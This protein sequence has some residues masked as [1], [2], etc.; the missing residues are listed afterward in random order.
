M[1]TGTGGNQAA[2][3]VLISAIL[4]SSMAFIDQS[5]LDVAAPRLQADLQMTGTQLF[6]V[7]TA[8]ALFLASLLLVGGALGDLYGRKRIFMIGI[9]IF[10]ASSI[11]CGLA[12]TAELLILSRAVQ[13][14]GGAL[15]IPGSL[16]MISAN[17]SDER[18]G[19][20]IGTWS[21][22][23][24]LTTLLGPLVGGWLAERGLWRAVFLINV[25][26]GLIALYLLASRVPES[27]SETPTRRLDWAGA[28]T[29]TLSLALF[30]IGFTL[31]QNADSGPL[32]LLMIVGGIGAL[33][34]FLVIESRIEHP[35][36]PLK[37]F[38]NRTFS[39]TNAL[40]LLLYG[41]LRVA[42]F[43][44][45]L[46]LQQIQGYP[47]DVAGFAFLPFALCLIALSRL[48][49]GLASRLGPR[50]FLTLGPAL[51]GVGFLLLGLPGQTGGVSDY[52]TTFFPGTLVL[53]VGMGLTVAPLTT[54][55]MSAAPRENSG[56]A[57]GINN[58]ISRVAAVLALT[59]VGGI[60]LANFQGGLAARAETLGLSEEA[61]VELS[62]NSA[63]LGA[64]E[65]PNGLSADQQTQV[66]QAIDESFL[67]VNRLVSVISAVLA[68]LSALIAFVM[69]EPK[70]QSEPPEPAAG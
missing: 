45:G 51:T 59:I 35:M 68:W 48:S 26:L 24:T 2:R 14:I 64:T 70:H 19:A 43:F 6:W 58:A 9:G 10:G 8:Y 3:W 62:A 22:F 65:L 23:S 38:R 30:T 67:E 46:N 4:A 13:G 54:A 49:G 60:A 16:A 63:A 44:L 33:I 1:T 40:T 11:A 41:A 27:R 29:I 52:W 56:A 57:S 50:L 12:P 34:G 53:G 18:R 37:L 39:G 47:A 7:S 42:P 15:M 21:T 69:V 25:P 5:A 20:A 31:L 55:V 66:K 17:F 28:V 61:R 32:S 36:V